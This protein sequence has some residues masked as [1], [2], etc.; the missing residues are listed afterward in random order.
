MKGSETAATKIL[1]VLFIAVLICSCIVPD[2]QIEPF[3]AQKIIKNRTKERAF[4][5]CLGVLNK[6]GYVL[7]SA[8][9]EEGLIRTD[10]FYFNRKSTNLFRY[11][12]I[13]QLYELNDQST[14]V[15]IESHFQRGEAFASRGLRTGSRPHEAEYVGWND[16]SADSEMKIFVDQFYQDLMN[17]SFRPEAKSLR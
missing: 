9:L 11:R 2:L 7:I 4:N 13:I 15:V 6:N 14:T 17:R 5:D 1:G 16:I 3:L 12:L 10:W 8:S